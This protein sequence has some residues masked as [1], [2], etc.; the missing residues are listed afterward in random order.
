MIQEG[1]IVVFA[2][3]QTDRT[4]GKLRPALALRACPGRYDDWLICM[5]SSQR[6]HAL[7]GIDEVID[8]T[9]NDFA[10]TG[11]KTASVVRATRIAVVASDVLRGT[12][13]TLAPERLTRIRRR[14]ANWVSGEPAAVPPE[15][16]DDM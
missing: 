7:A 11:F 1:Q 2:F 15:G 3:P 4:S 12:I 8:Q 13:G 6:R 16:S 5:I 10:Q 14:I 9:D